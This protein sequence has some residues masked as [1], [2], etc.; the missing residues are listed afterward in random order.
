M[1]SLTFIREQRRKSGMTQHQLARAAGVS[2]SLIAKIESGRIDA[3][4]SKVKAILEALDRTQLTAE[5]TAGEIMHTG[6]ETVSP[7]ES[8]HAVAQAMRKHSISQ[9]PV[10]EAKQLVGA[11]TEQAILS[12]FSSEPKKMATLRVSDAM[13]DAFPTA[14]PSTPISAVASLLRHH[15]AVLVMEKGKIA[16]IIT[17]ADLL[18]TI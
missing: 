7:S 10:V 14:L 5:K 13:E 15:S 17:K 9:M 4:Y 3:A 6:I 11:I 16:G 1:E 2:Q 8:L 18:K 12:H